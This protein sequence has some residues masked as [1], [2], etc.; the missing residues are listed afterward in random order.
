MMGFEPPTVSDEL[1]VN[2]RADDGRRVTLVTGGNGF[3]GPFL[4]EQ[5][6]ESGRRVVVYDAAPL[7][8]EGRFVLGPRAEDVVF[9]RGSIDDQGRLFDVVKLHQPH[10]LV[11]M[12]MLVD[13]GTLAVERTRGFRI[14]VAGTQLMLEATRTFG[15]ER[16]VYFSSIGVLTRVQY[17]PID[18]AHP[19]VLP[20]SG[21]G[22]GFYGAYK[23]AG[24]AMCFAYNQ[25]FGTNVRM[26]RPSAVYGLGMNEYPGPIKRM[27]EGTV[28]G[29]RLR[30]PT[31]GAH[32]RS[33]THVI[34]V[35]WLTL[36]LLEA[37]ADADRIFFA[38]TGEPL[39]TTTEV[40]QIVRDVPAGGRH[41]DR[42]RARPR[43]FGHGG[44]ARPPLD[45]ER[46]TAARLGAALPVPQGWNRAVRGALRCLQRVARP[47]GLIDRSP[48]RLAGRAGRSGR[49]RAAG[50]AA[51]PSQVV[52]CE[53]FQPPEWRLV[54]KGAV[55]SASIGEVEPAGEGEAPLLGVALGGSSETR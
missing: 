28:R 5:L 31:G 12:A 4:V 48:F 50:L 27:V 42:R 40:A 45:R 3:V 22:A 16:V 49:R 11:H 20:D 13:P 38:A 33:Y 6:L 32:R 26:I 9:E 54:V 29:E 14:D 41:R 39:P 47:A 1:A 36:A 2:R 34:D 35:A 18:T 17:E 44:P 53:R 37:P 46:S 25:A 51:R 15:I 43:R 30:F 10:E 21:P 52:P 55:W 24:E 7:R 23:V 8:D 19:V